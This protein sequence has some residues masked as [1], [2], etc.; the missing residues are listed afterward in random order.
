MDLIPDFEFG[1]ATQTILSQSQDQLQNSARLIN[2][3]LDDTARLEQ[4]RALTPVYFRSAK[5]VILVLDLSI[6]SSFAELPF[7]VGMLSG[8]CPSAVPY[9]V[10]NKS[11]LPRVIPMSEASEYA[12]A[13]GAY[14]HE[15]WAKESRRLTE[16]FH[17]VS[18]DYVPS[19]VP[20]VAEERVAI[21]PRRKSVS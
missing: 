18:D 7:F 21:L 5:I 3:D 14:Y 16:F 10:G 1:V 2:L 12:D 11:D 20:I 15:P 6:R 19:K 4:Y 8:T 13:I 9:L 17:A